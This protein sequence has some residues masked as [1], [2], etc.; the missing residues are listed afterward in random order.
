MMAVGITGSFASYS[1]T[2]A[3]YRRFTRPFPP[4]AFVYPVPYLLATHP[5]APPR[6]AWILPLAA[7]TRLRAA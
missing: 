6:T 7:S 2:E 3:E 1:N 5:L 4:A